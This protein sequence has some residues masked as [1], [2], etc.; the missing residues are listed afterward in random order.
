[1]VN[2]SRDR[3]E[4][5]VRE[6]AR[7][8]KPVRIIVIRARSAGGAVMLANSAGALGVLWMPM[9]PCRRRLSRNSWNTS[10]RQVYHC[11]ALDAGC[12]DQCPTT[13]KR[14]LALGDCS[15]PWCG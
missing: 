9:V 10:A 4:D 8:H 11:F 2:G 5:V 1:M 3:T 14:R 12:A 7:V 13:F 6:Y 15:T